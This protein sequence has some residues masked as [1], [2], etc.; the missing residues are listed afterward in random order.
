MIPELEAAKKQLRDAIVSYVRAAYMACGSVE[1]AT[2]ML[3]KELINMS[4]SFTEA[5]FA[6][7]GDEKKEGAE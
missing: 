2:I 1:V 3:S 5:D 4:E 6:G 7:L